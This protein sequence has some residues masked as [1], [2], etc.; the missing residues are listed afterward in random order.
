MSD[1]DDL[2]LGA[3]NNSESTTYLIARPGDQGPDV[4]MGFAGA[5]FVEVKPN[6][7]LLA[8]PSASHTGIFSMGVGPG[9]GVLGVGSIGLRGESNSPGAGMGVVGTGA[10][11]VRGDGTVGVLGVNDHT[12]HFG[13]GVRGEGHDGVVGV[14]T[15]G[16]N[17]VLGRGATGVFGQGEGQY[18]TGVHGLGDQYGV[19]G[20]GETGIVGAGSAGPGVQAFSTQDRAGHFTSKKVA[21]LH[22]VPIDGPADP[23][24]IEGPA[25]AGDLLVLLHRQHEHED[26]VVEKASLWFCTKGDDFGPAN[27]KQLA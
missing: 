11:G 7:A 23:A 25:K 4:L 27:W 24:Q 6:P 18:G 14:S 12:I 10:T 13:Q 19:R 5:N 22:L 21:Q 9:V 8:Q 3:H 15:T 26:V 20:Q 1:G 16:N 17:G 2:E